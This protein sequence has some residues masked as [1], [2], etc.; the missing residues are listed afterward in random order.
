MTLDG[1][2]GLVVA[3]NG[4]YNYSDSALKSDVV[5]ANSQKAL[6]VLKAVEAKVYKRTDL[7]D[8]GLRLGFIAQDVAKALPPEWASSIVGSTGGFDEHLDE[9]GNTVPA[10]PSTMTLDYA[11]LVCCLWAA[12][13][14]MLARLKALEARLQ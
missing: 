8:K 14:S 10:K 6:D 2:N 9:E 7:Q 13:R 5:P 12:N 11:R 1:S 3:H 4:L